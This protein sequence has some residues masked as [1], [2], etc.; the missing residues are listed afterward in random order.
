MYLLMLLATFMSA[1]YGFNLSAR[2]DYD[3]DVARKKAMGVISRFMYQHRFATGVISRIKAQTDGYVPPDAPLMV[4]PEDLIYGDTEEGADKTYT[5]VY[6][7]QHELG[8]DESKFLLREV[9]GDSLSGNYMLIDRKLIPGDEMATKLI[10]LKRSMECDIGDESDPVCGGPTEMCDMTP[11]EFDDGSGTKVL[12]GSCCSSYSESKGGGYLVSFMKLDARWRSR[13]T[14]G[15]SLDFWRAIEERKYNENIGVISWDG[16]AWRFRGRLQFLP[17]YRKDKEQWEAANDAD[18]VYPVERK[19]MTEWVLP[20]LI[21]DE[22]FFVV[23][24]ENL[25]VNGCLFRIKS[26][27]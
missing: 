27:M 23:N 6:Q 3:R 25:C 18:L 24:G 15:I 16:G 12:V 9:S 2:P 4:L 22:D 8:K 5:M 7:Q 17:A 26:F 11:H 14:G 21:F 1:I 10:C 19:M 20:K 13:V